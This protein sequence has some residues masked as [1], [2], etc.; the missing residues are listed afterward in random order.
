MVLGQREF[1]TKLKYMQHNFL[2]PSSFADLGG[3]VFES[4]SAHAEINYNLFMS[5]HHPEWVARYAKFA[6]P[7]LPSCAPAY[8][9]LSRHQKFLQEKGLWKE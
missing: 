8:P 6:L 4:R 9:F 2:A 5:V 1:S 7:T 3:G